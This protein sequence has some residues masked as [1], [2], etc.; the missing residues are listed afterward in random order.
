[1]PRFPSLAAALLALSALALPATAATVRYGFAVETTSGPLAGQT[2]NG[3]FEF[4]GAASVSGP[5]GETLYELTAFSFDFDGTTFGLA[6]LEYGDAVFDGATFAGLDAAGP[7]FAFLPAIGGLPAA[8]IYD[9]GDTRVGDGDVTYRQAVPEPT[10]GALL[11]AAVLG[12]ATA[13]R[14]RA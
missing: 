13:R 7:G 1:M 9:F 12:W 10:T 11:A 5:G 6:D 8:F 3:S 2:F 4:D 14:R